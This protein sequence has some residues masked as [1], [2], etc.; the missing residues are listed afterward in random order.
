MRVLYSRE[1]NTEWGYL[2]G[3]ERERKEGKERA[4]VYLLFLEANCIRNKPACSP[5]SLYSQGDRIGIRSWLYSSSS[6]HYSLFRDILNVDRGRVANINP[7]PDVP[8]SLQ[9]EPVSQQGEHLHVDP[10]QQVSGDV[11]PGVEEE[12][13]VRPQHLHRAR[14]GDTR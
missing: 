13:G 5:S 9:A 8:S 10:A 3:R 2:L 12:L 6:M 4:G 11:R 1:G 7:I 14:L